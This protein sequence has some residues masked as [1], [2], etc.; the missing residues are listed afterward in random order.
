MGRHPFTMSFVLV[1]T[2]WRLSLV[3]RC[4]RKSKKTN[5]CIQSTLGKD[6]KNCSAGDE[7][8]ATDKQVGGSNPT[9]SQSVAVSLDK[10]LNPLC[11]VQIRGAVSSVCCG[12]AVATRALH[13]QQCES[14]ANEQW[15]HCKCVV[16]R[17]LDSIHDYSHE[18]FLCEFYSL[19]TNVQLVKK[20]L[21]SK[22][23]KKRGRPL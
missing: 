21:K 8:C 22:S 14:G 7:A 13:H 20:W 12:A 3:T 6:C 1:A 17:S 9:Q 5:A 10:T 11:L 15:V 23:G 19:Q 16:Y 4:Y 2:Q 18:H